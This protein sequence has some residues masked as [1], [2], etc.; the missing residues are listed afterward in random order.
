MHV[1]ELVTSALQLAGAY[2]S[3]LALKLSWQDYV[4]RRRWFVRRRDGSVPRQGSRP[5]RAETS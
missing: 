3:F 4:L 2:L 5:E 1:I